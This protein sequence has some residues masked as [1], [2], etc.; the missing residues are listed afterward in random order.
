MDFWIVSDENPV[1]GIFET[2]DIEASFN[3]DTNR[4]RMAITVNP[5]GTIEIIDI[6]IIVV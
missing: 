5:V 4:L 6:P 2:I 3:K 1:H